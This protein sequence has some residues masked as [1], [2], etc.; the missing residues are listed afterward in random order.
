MIRTTMSPRIA[1]LLAGLGISLST[2]VATPANA[3][4]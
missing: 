1:I 2:I 4:N 3:Q